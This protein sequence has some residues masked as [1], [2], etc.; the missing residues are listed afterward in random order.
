M[1]AAPQQGAGSAEGA[2]RGLNQDNRTRWPK[3]CLKHVASCWTIKLGELP[4]RGVGRGCHCSETGWALV[5]KWWR[6]ALCITFL[7]TLFVV[8]LF[9]L[10]LKKSS[11][12]CFFFP[13]RNCLYL[14]QWAPTSTVSMDAVWD[15]WDHSQKADVS[16]V[17]RGKKVQ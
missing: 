5:S 4:G 16:T 12:C 3:G 9:W 2:E 14:N 1:L 13:C 7:C 15:L 10:F 8:T 17:I 11:F 6:S